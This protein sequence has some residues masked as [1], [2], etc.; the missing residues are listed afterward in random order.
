MNTLTVAFLF[1]NHYP[2]KY[3][4]MSKILLFMFIPFNL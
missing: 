2:V 4:N 3:T 1:I